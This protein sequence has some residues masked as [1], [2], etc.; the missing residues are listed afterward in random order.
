MY[1]QY[2]VCVLLSGTILFT[3]V[4]LAREEE[5]KKKVS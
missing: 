3:L 5:K 2:N 1:I 4:L